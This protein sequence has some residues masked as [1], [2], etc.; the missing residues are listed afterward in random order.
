MFTNKG[1]FDTLFLS[2]GEFQTIAPIPARCLVS[3]CGILST[4]STVCLYEAYEGDYS[5]FV[6]TETGEV[7]TCAPGTIF[8]EYNCSCVHGGICR[9]FLMLC[10]TV[11]RNKR[12]VCVLT[13]CAR[14]CERM[15]SSF[16]LLERLCTDNLGGY[17]FNKRIL[18]ESQN[19]ET[20]LYPHTLTSG[21]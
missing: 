13:L 7:F 17:I 5:R 3:C 15:C 9:I 11:Q 2:V 8:D 19:K 18:N 6:S 10:Y 16:Y 4:D 21:L 1:Y 14:V 20:S 12:I